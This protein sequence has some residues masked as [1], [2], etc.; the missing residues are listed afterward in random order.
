MTRC[1]CGAPGFVGIVCSEIG[2]RNYCREH[3]G[4]AIALIERIADDED[5]DR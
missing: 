3:L 1:P 4:D 2:R 5:G